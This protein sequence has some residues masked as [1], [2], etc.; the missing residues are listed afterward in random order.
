MKYSP[1]FTGEKVSCSACHSMLG[2]EAVRRADG[3]VTMELR[4]AN[5][6]CRIVG[7]TITAPEA[8]VVFTGKDL[9]A[10]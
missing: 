9:S 10:S 2:L 8:G 5:G 4:C 1:C 6:L 3:A 7:L